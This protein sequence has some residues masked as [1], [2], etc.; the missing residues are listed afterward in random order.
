M[1]L[2]SFAAY[3]DL[4][5]S[6]VEHFVKRSCVTVHVMVFPFLHSMQMLDKTRSDLARAFIL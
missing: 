1:L 6:I 5:A 2:L 3:T 4:A